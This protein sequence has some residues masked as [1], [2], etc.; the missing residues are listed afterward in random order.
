M[1]ERG[2]VPGSTAR[3]ATTVD[4]GD[5]GVALVRLFVER[6]D[7]HGGELAL[8]YK[9][10]G[11]WHE[12]TWAQVR[13]RV[14]HL[15]LGLTQLGVGPGDRVAVMGRPMAEWVYADLATQSLGGVTA[16]LYVTT[17]N[18]QIARQLRISGARVFVAETLEY[19]DDLLDAERTAGGT[20]LVDHIIVISNRGL[21]GRTD[22]RVRSIVDVEADGAK[23]AAGPA[24]PWRTMVEQR[25][26]DA[27][28]RLFF[29]AG[30]T[31]DP[32]AV[33]LSTANVVDPWRAYLSS[34]PKP[35]GPGDLS[36]SFLPLA[37]IG[38]TAFSIVLPILYGSVPHFPEDEETVGEAL[39][40]VSPTLLFAFPRLL[41]LYASNALVD[42]ETGSAVKRHLYGLA[43]RIGGPLAYQM[44]HRH[45]LDKFGFRKVRIALVGGSKV[46][47]EVVALWRLWGLRL[48]RYYGLTEAGGLSA[49][50]A[51]GGEDLSSV[52]G[53]ELRIGADDEVLVRGAGVFDGYLA[54]TND[55][56]RLDAE[57]WLHTGDIG[58][59]T[60]GG[61]RVLDRS[62]ALLH[63]DDGTTVIPS[64][65]EN[66]LKF[67]SYVTDAMVVPLGGSRLGAL[68][69]LNV[70][71]VAL[72]ARGEKILFTAASELVD[73]PRVGELIGVAVDEANRRLA[74]AGSAHQV[75]A[76]RIMPSDTGAG[77]TPTGTLRR[78]RVAAQHA[79]LINDMRS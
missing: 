59:A 29:T 78:T 20:P 69:G 28:I 60:A 26:A 46:S 35:P 4:G 54:D 57:G 52:S 25:S 6:A 49:V 14:E 10:L 47:T 72:W 73:N 65:I 31:G 3:A 41:D 22:P 40:E 67:G 58:V 61:I 48:S 68:I 39:I 23:L 16:G 53:V 32:K 15:A 45:L 33:A 79:A 43:G 44:V 17:T 12:V 64:E 13:E 51:P 9:R 30:T 36:V 42:L 70:E 7:R 71:N 38:E 2:T 21:L 34:L 18:D 62:A 5:A 19:V 77:M 74:G 63:N 50:A 75:I 11:I 1:T 66:A 76:F 8:R 24:T 37:H 55:G 27:P 56:V